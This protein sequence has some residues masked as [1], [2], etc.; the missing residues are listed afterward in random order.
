MAALVSEGV[1]A[2]RASREAGEW[3]AANG[4]QRPEFVNCMLLGAVVTIISIIVP[5]LSGLSAMTD[6]AL[7][8]EPSNVMLAWP[9]LPTMIFAIA[10]GAA[11]VIWRGPQATGWLARQFGGAPTP[12]QAAIWLHLAAAASIVISL[13]I[14]VVDL[15]LGLAGGGLPDGV[16]LLSLALSLASLVILLT[17]MSVLAQNILGIA[18]RRRGI[19]FSLLWVFGI[20]AVTSAVWTVTYALLGGG[21]SS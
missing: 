1:F 7:G 10:A 15:V 5:E 21:A 20:L 12:M 8:D 14:A 17:V 6:R 3:R 9:M 18:G 11:L 4:L 13:A 19:L 16:G 2:L